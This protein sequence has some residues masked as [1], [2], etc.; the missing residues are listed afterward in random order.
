MDLGASSVE[1]RDAERDRDTDPLDY[2]RRWSA[3][4]LG[5]WSIDSD[6]VNVPGDS[7]RDVEEKERIQTILDPLSI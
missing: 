1:D 7:N 6:G 4:D 2:I 5:R 3:T